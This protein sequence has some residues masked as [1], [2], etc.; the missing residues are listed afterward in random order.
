MLEWK[1]KR[2]KPEATPKVESLS[3]VPC[4]TNGFAINMQNFGLSGL[5][6]IH[7]IKQYTLEMREGKW[8]GTISIQIR[9]SERKWYTLE[10]S[11]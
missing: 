7:L 6:V 4:I 2:N 1:I 10:A 3:F 11:E 5:T 8:H 9:K